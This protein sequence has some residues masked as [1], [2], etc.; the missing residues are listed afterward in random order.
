MLVY[1]NVNFG[2]QN[3]AQG[4]IFRVNYLGEW[5]DSVGWDQADN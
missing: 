4:R 1:K 3:G 2:D 5:A